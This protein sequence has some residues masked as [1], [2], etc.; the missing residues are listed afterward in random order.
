MVLFTLSSLRW[1]KIGLFC[2]YDASL[3]N[4]R[5]YLYLFMISGTSLIAQTVKVLPA[6]QQMQ[7]NAWVGKISR[8]RAWLPTPVFLSGEFHGQ[9]SLAGYIPWGHKELD[10]IEQL[11]MHA[12]ILS[13]KLHPR[14][15]L[16]TI[17][18]TC[19]FW[20][21]ITAVTTTLEASI[22]DSIQ[23]IFKDAVAWLPMYLC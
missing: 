6:R 7:I 1:L 10:L 20:K 21:L 9:R 2:K 13:N 19:H 16:C 22:W 18:Q 23:F 8:R 4:R 12:C 15:L 5:H 11:G 17:T 14:F 3:E